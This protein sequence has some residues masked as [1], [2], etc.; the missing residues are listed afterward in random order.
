MSNQKKIEV[1]TSEDASTVNLAKGAEIMEKYEKE[2]RTRSFDWQWLVKVIYFLCMAFTLYHLAYASGI[3]LL[4]MVNI[5][6]HAIHVGLILMLGFALYPAFKKSSRK[7]IAWY[8]WIFMAL[9]AAMP[10][11]VFLRYP[12]FISTGFQGEQIDIIMGTIL[13]F[14]VL[15]CSRRISGL[16]LPILSVLFLV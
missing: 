8:D 16:A 2:S 7:R 11:Y 5:K 9:S 1:P 6:H 13:I 10:I 4:Q 14:L 15:E 12:T 3:R